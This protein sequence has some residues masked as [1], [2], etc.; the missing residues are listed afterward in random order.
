MIRKDNEQKRISFAE[1]AKELNQ[2][3]ENAD[4]A[5]LA[6]LQQLAR[7]RAIRRTSMEREQAR[8][9][10]KLGAAHPRVAALNRKLEA[11]REL[12]RDIALGI[13][14]ARTPAIRPDAGAWILHGHVRNQARNGLP[15]LTVALYDEKNKWIEVLGYACTDADGYFRL[16]AR[17]DATDAVGTAPEVNQ[18]QKA[19]TSFAGKAAAW[20]AAY[21]HVTDGQGATLYVGESVLTP[22]PGEV[23]YREIILDDGVCVCTPP[24]GKQPIRERKQDK[25]K[26]GRYLGNRRKQEV[27]DLK[28]TKPGCQIEEIKAGQREYFTTQKEAVAVGYDFC[29]YCF[30]KEKS[31]R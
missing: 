12:E 19:A 15:G 23:V 3:L 1:I 25:S 30:G 16:T 4:P 22:K 27:H 10:Q 13:S 20:G 7:M 2:G 28:N 21:I 24:G 6:G 18:L 9:S 26:E 5:R 31:K 14:R 11:N 17:L 29:A 8:L